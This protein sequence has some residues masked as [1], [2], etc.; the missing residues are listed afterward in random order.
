MTFGLVIAKHPD[1]DR[2]TGCPFNL[3]SC[4]NEKK[5]VCYYDNMSFCCGLGVLTT[6]A[7]LLL[8]I[9]IV[10][11]VGMIYFLLGDKELPEGDFGCYIS[12]LLCKIPKISYGDDEM[13]LNINH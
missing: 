3:P 1:Y 12:Y 13:P 5:L 7:L 8:L 6:I 10:N 2:T 9:C 11:V 4:P